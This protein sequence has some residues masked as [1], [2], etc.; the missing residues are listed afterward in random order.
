MTAFAAARSATRPCSQCGGG[1]VRAI[2]EGS[3]VLP[4]GHPL[5]SCVNVV[6]CE[7]C[8]FCF[9]DT[10]CRREDYDRYYRELSKY[11]DTKVSTGAGW[12]PE[13]R[14]RLDDTAGCIFGMAGPTQAAVLDVGCGAGGLLDAL[15]AV[16]YPTLYGMDPAAACATAVT[17]RGHHGVVG[18]LDDHPLAPCMFH[19]VILCHVL[20]HVRDVASALEAVRHLLAPGGWLYVEVPDAARYAECLI[21]PFQD[22]NL[23]HINH[24]TLRSLGN[25]L[26][27]HGWQVMRQ[28][29][30]TLPLPGGRKYPAIYAW[31]RPSVAS[32]AEVDHGG[33]QSLVEYVR[34][35]NEL[36]QAIDRRLGRA[37]N[38]REIAVWGVGQMTMRLLAGSRLGTARI[39]AFV[40]SNPVHQGKRLA[41]TPILAPDEV[42]SRLSADVPIVIGSL[43]NLSAIEATI[44]SRGIPN[45]ILRLDTEQGE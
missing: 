28:E 43:V 40:D 20:E 14:E 32:P 8:G 29:S 34:V 38:G 13:D 37:I 12:S 31:A 24:F 22:F 4:E 44:R 10:A 33:R 15:S 27:T 2:H 45:P 5:A 21:A 41:G 17:E 16:G 18:S 19:G 39:A 11:A 25:M 1:I 30:K 35:S 42:L 36:M 3:Y 23:E 6:S 9:N 26:R 7:Q